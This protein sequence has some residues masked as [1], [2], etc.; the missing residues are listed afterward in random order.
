MTTYEEILQYAEQAV[1]AQ[2]LRDEERR[3]RNEAINIEERLRRKLR[4]N[5]V[6]WRTLKSKSPITIPTPSG[7]VTL[8][9]RHNSDTER[10]VQVI[11]SERLTV[12]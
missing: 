11:V 9:V 2:R 12:S 3:S 6:L 8:V 7:F 1:C 4:D 5:T 10:Q